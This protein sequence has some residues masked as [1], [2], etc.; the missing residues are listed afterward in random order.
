MGRQIPQPIISIV[1]EY[2][3]SAETHAKLDNLFAYADAPGEPPEGSKHA[4]ALAWL[5]RI[6][7]ESDDTL[8]D[9]R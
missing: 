2:I 1:A 8:K 7:K 4:K 3:S 5:R 9:F 6:N